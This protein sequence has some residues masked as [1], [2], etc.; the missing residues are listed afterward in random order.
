MSTYKH[1]LTLTLIVILLSIAFPLISTPVPAAAADT[2]VAMA[3]GTSNDL[4][5]VWGSSAGNI[6]VVGAS[7]TILNYDGRAWSTM[8]SG[9]SNNLNDIWGSSIRNIFAVGAGGTILHYNGTSWSVMTSNTTA[10]LYGIW[11]SSPD[12]IWAVGTAYSI[13]HYNGSTW[14]STTSAMSN[15]NKSIWGASA[16]QVFMVGKGGMFPAGYIENYDGNL[17]NDMG[18]FTFGGLFGI[19]GISSDNVY[20]VGGNGTIMH[21]GNS[22]SAM[23]SSTTN[24][25]KGVW[26]NCSNS[27]FVVGAGGV[28]LH[29]GSGCRPDSIS[30]NPSSGIQGQILNNVIISGTN[31]ITGQTAVNFSGSGVT[32]SNVNVTSATQLTATITTAADAAPGARD[33]SVTTA[34]GTGTLNGGFTVNQAA[35]IVTGVNP[36]SGMQGQTISNV[37]IAGTYFT[38]TTSVRF[39]AL[40]SYVSV[41]SFLVDNDTQITANITI[42]SYASPGT[43]NVTVTTPWGTNTLNG[44]FTVNRA[45]QQ[46]QTVNTATGTGVATFTTSG[47][48]INNLR[49]LTTTACGTLAGYSFPHGFFSFTISNLTPGSTVILTITLP[50]NMPADTKY[51]KC[52]NGQWMDI[53]SML[54][55]NDGDNTLTLTLRD[56]GPEDADGHA[57]GTITDPGAPATPTTPEVIHTRP[58]SSSPYIPP[59][60]AAAVALPNVVVQSASLSIS[61]VTP[62]TPVIVGV[63]LVNKSTVNG[64]LNV[65]LYVNGREEASQGVTVNSG[66]TLPIS[67]NVSR[68][69]PGTY[70]VYVGSVSAGSFTVDE[71]AD[72]NTILYIS[73]AL[74]GIAFVIGLLLILR[75][76]QPGY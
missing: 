27:V 53:T 13:M 43:R 40:G 42:L 34:G 8:N 48:S 72:P 46:T 45:G 41:N 54:G 32:A 66:S 30:V 74:L 12:D 29:Y 67:F 36:N 23:T 3:S 35:P 73:G 70:S 25:L 7:G 75:R 10:E 47:G 1:V 50:S 4:N 64:A 14:S 5:G 39:G 18:I 11:G 71:L 51:W 69:Q 2:W 9:T 21:Y 44:G 19:Y 24:T 68:D 57:D 49:A 37:I 63:T 62:G 28:I 6:F 22:W 17:W 52:I 59:P 38:G 60:L 15:N 26:G 58:P 16:S 65:K 33:V 55:D 20:A 76:R 61:K 56:G 31:F